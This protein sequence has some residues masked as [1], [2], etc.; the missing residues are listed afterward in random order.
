MSN[1]TFIE[2]SVSASQKVLITDSKFFNLAMIGGNK[3]LF[4]HITENYEIINS[5]ELYQVMTSNAD[6]CG[7]LCVVYKDD[8][9]IK[10]ISSYNK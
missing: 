8:K 4:N 1:L 6:D 10:T 9:E 5:K 7:G 3:E 2:D